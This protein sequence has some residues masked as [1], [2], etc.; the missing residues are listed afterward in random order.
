MNSVGTPVHLS[1]SRRK[2]NNVH[3]MNSPGR[4]NE[5]IFPL[6]V[7][8]ALP[9]CSTANQPVPS[10]AEACWGVG[11]IFDPLLDEQDRRSPHRPRL[12]SNAETERRASRF[13]GRLT[14]LCADTSRHQTRVVGSDT[15]RSRA[16]KRGSVVRPRG[17]LACREARAPQGLDAP[18]RAG[19]A[20]DGEVEGCHLRGRRHVELVLH[21]LLAGLILTGCQF[22]LPLSD[23]R[24]HDGGVRV[25]MAR[26]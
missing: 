24:T 5:G 19:S 2:L 9:N 12:G 8:P 3:L 16:K 22:R 21:D 17:R 10:F 14:G 15:D 23:L 4:G 11:E 7:L 20:R 1:C 25:L 26:V 13:A 18:G 6:R